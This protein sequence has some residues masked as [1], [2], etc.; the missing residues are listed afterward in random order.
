MTPPIAHL[1]WVP[2]QPEDIPAVRAI[3]DH[4]H[5]SLPE[6]AEVLAEKQRLFPAGANKLLQEGRMVGYSFCHPWSDRTIPPLDALLGSLP[7]KTDCLYLHDLAVLPEARGHGTAASFMNLARGIAQ[8]HQLPVQ[9]CV[10]V[11]GTDQLWARFGFRTEI[12][13]ELE[14]KLA[15]YGPTAKYMR[16]AKVALAVETGPRT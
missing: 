13:P 5:P 11:Y 2:L 1:T 4:V 9:A 10:S 6:R 15:G 14:T 8:R 3:A 7:E 16:Q 12:R